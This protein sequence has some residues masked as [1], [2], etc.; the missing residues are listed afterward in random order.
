MAIVRWKPNNDHSWC[1]D[2]VMTVVKKPKGR[3]YYQRP[4]DNNAVP[5]LTHFYEWVTNVFTGASSSNASLIYFVN[6]LTLSLTLLSWFTG[7][8]VDVGVG[9]SIGFFG[10]GFSF[11]NPSPFVVLGLLIVAMR[12]CL[13][14]TYR[15]KFVQYFIQLLNYLMS[16]NMSNTDNFWWFI[17]GRCNR[18]WLACLLWPQKRLLFQL[19]QTFSHVNVQARSR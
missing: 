7:F 4:F 2:Q 14:I 17:F 11:V 1:Y 18:P 6:S 5:W 10:I 8:G 19:F 13:W 15:L 12:T 9:L 16:N 3:R